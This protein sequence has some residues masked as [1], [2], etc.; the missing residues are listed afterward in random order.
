MQVMTS[1]LQLQWLHLPQLGGGVC[2]KT[3]PEISC[4]KSHILLQVQ[5]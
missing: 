2:H 5:C 3:Q 4:D 1:I